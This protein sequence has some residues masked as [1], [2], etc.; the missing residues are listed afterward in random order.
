M[1]ILL[2]YPVGAG[3]EFIGCTVNPVYA[4]AQPRT[5]LYN[6][7]LNRY[8]YAGNKITSADVG[9]DQLF[10]YEEGMKNYLKWMDFIP[11][12]APHRFRRVLPLKEA[13][14]LQYQYA[15]PFDIRDVFEDPLEPTSPI[16]VMH[17]HSNIHRH[18]KN[19]KAYCLISNNYALRLLW[20][21]C[22]WFKLDPYTNPPI[23]KIDQDRWTN[24]VCSIDDGSYNELALRNDA[25]YEDYKNKIESDVEM[26]TPSELDLIQD[27][28]ANKYKEYTEINIERIDRHIRANKMSFQVFHK[29][30]YT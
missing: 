1:S 14:F 21:L 9:W 27:G 30:E 2:I 26:I 28:L 25:L 29:I 11:L 23:D 24:A 13:T 5:N 18:F 6:S 7:K 8:N 10:G 3:G 19:V 22:C 16:L 15:N 17:H 12:E 4:P 20:A